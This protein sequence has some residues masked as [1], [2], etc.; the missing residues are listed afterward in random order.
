MVG[1]KGDFMLSVYNSEAIYFDQIASARGSIPR[2]KS[3]G[4]K[5]QPCF[6]PLKTLK[7]V[8]HKQFVS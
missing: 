5:G 7:Q 8:D 2:A 4:N 6:I 3:N 1:V